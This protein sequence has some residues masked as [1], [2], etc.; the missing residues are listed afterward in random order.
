MRLFPSLVLAG[1]CFA[2]V[3]SW[4]FVDEIKN[5]EI[6]ARQGANRSDSRS[7]RED[8]QRSGDF[9]HL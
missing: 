8:L 5:V 2:S 4:K 3:L 6:V 9:W 7:Y 1:A